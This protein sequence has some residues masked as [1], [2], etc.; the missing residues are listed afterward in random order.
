M[1]K[2]KEELENM[3]DLMEQK[4]TLSQKLEVRVGAVQF[5]WPVTNKE[6]SYCTNY[7]VSP[8]PGD[9]TTQPG[10]GGAAGRG[11]TATGGEPGGTREFQKE[12][13][14]TAGAAGRQDL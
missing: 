11:R 10:A 3:N 6:L 7:T 5:C 2:L 1:E 9:R 12:S 13:A 4:D 14:D 8:F